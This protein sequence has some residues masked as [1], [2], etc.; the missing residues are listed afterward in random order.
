MLTKSPTIQPIAANLNNHL[1]N[2]I[3]DHTKGGLHNLNCQVV[4]NR[5]LL[6]L[7]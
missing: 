5:F 1:N 3:F 7:G 4:Y 6:V 2:R